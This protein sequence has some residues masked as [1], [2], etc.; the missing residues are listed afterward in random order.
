MGAICPCCFKKKPI[1]RNLSFSDSTHN[2]VPVNDSNNLANNNFASNSF[3]KSDRT[4]SNQVDEEQ[5][6]P[7]MESV[8]EKSLKSSEE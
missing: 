7:L 1:E 6:A 3:A 5:L 2:S 8:S 4:Y